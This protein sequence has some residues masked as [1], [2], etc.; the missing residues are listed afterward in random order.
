M[1]LNLDL[2]FEPKLL[3]EINNIGIKKYF[4]EGDTI[5]NIGSNIKSMPILIS[6]VLKILREDHNGDELLLYF[7]KQGESCAMTLNCCT[8][9]AKSEIRAVAET[10]VEILFLP[11]RKM[12]EWSTNY[13]SW[14][15]FVFDSYH[16]RFSEL[17][18][19]IDK[20]A[21]LNMDERLLVLLKDKTELQHSLEINQTHQE[22]A[23]ELNT[24]RVV[25]SRLLK[26]LERLG[27]IE[28]HRN[29]IKI[30]HL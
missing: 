3:E 7:L 1:I 11:N 5:I 9:N 12:E 29:R 30:I 10:N 24:S 15:N 27:K 28:L 13:K 4:V 23:N 14:R 20:I 25:I 22:I 2:P 18:E 8:R 16:Q 6:G 17:L 19:T 21:F 26:K